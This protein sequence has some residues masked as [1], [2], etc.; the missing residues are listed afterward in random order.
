VAA[1]GLEGIFSARVVGASKPARH[2]KQ[3]TTSPPALA[4][5]VATTTAPKLTTTCSEGAN[6][7]QVRVTQDPAGPD[8]GETA[9]E[10]VAGLVTVAVV[11]PVE[12]AVGWVV[13]TD[14]APED[15][16]PGWPALRD[17]QPVPAR[18]ATT[19]TVAMIRTGRMPLPQ[20]ARPCSGS[21]SRA[22]RKPVTAGCR[23]SVA[24]GANQPRRSQ[25]RHAERTRLRSGQG[26]RASVKAPAAGPQR[27]TKR[28]GRVAGASRCT[29]GGSESGV[30]G[31]R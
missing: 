2:R 14:E 26:A 29:H 3:G 10:A 24:A 15:G 22:W 6:R 28:P 19:M 11:E 21:R 23:V 30:A 25:D 31:L 20:Q 7:R 4:L 1:L 8:F 18:V 17:P 12:A 9:H 5:A 27:R 16:A 13:V